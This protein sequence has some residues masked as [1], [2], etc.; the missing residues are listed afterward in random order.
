MSA[1]VARWTNSDRCPVCDAHSRLAKGQGVR[2]YGF[3][4]SDSLY[5]HCTREEHAGRLRPHRDNECGVTYAHR[6]AGSCRC[7]LEHGGSVPSDAFRAPRIAPSEKPWNLDSSHIEMVHRYKVE[8]AHA[9]EVC[10]L[11]KRSRPLFSGATTF[12]RHRGDDGLLYWGIGERWRGNPKRPLYRQDEALEVLKHGG[13]LYLV[14]GERD[15][16][17]MVGEGFESA[18]SPFGAG[19]FTKPQALRIRRAMRANPESSVRIIADDDK[20]GVAHALAVYKLITPTADLRRRVTVTRPPNDFH[21]MA[22]A[23]AAGTE[24]IHGW[25]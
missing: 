6:L 7:G 11:W 22:D 2:C 14:E 13:R 25:G 15:V 5:A 21:D 9:F 10:R 3:L 4:S 19:K 20:P 23:I 24:A 12:P 1:R 8:G 17:A 18:C 16:D